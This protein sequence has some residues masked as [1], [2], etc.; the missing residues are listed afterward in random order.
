[1]VKRIVPHV[2][3]LPNATDEFPMQLKRIHVW[4]VGT[5][6]QIFEWRGETCV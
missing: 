3:G 5:R 6:R 2:N 4:I 1:M